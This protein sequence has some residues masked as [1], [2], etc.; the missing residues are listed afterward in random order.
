MYL[1]CPNCRLTV[2]RERA[3]QLGESPVCPR[4]AARGIN[5]PL[6]RRPGRFFRGVP[7]EPQVAPAAPVEADDTIS[8][9]G[10]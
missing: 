3:P 1:H 9:S 7:S 4:C 8:T 5:V 2:H 10:S 6:T